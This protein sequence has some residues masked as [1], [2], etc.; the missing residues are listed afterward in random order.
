M[1]E[2]C[3]SAGASPARHDTKI[4]QKRLDID[5]DAGTIIT[6]YDGNIE[7]TVGYLKDDVINAAYLVQPPADVAVV[8]V[9]GGRDILSALYFGAKSITES[10]SIPRSSKSSPTSSPNSPAIS[11]ASPACRWSTPKPAAT[12]ITHPI[13]TTS[14]RFR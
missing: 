3:R 10:R 12:S 6:K 2:I 1:G 4:D 11:I 9:G 5:A 7:Q 8:G 14:S 13:A